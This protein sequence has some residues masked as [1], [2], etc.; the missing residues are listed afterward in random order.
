[1]NKILFWGQ[2]WWFWAL[3]AGIPVAGYLG[4]QFLKDEGYIADY[5]TLEDTYDPMEEVAI[6][7]GGYGG[8]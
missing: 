6:G 3:V 5:P 2:Y 7:Y 4:Y 1:M 8:R